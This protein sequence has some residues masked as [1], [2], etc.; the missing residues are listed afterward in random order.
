MRAV[1]T[2]I[3]GD[4]RRRRV[5]TFVVFIIVALAAGVGTLALEILSVSSAPYARA[6]AQDAGAH[7]DVQFDGQKV[8]TAQLSATAQL[9]DVTVTAGP[10][11]LT[12]I[13]FEYGTAKAALNVIGR[14]DPGG[15][16]D[17]L[18]IVAGRWAR[19]PG[20]IV[21]TQSFAEQAHLAPGDHI[22]ALSRQ[23]KP[24]FT[25][26]GEVVD[27]EEADAS[28]MSPQFSWVVPEQVA[29][30]LSPGNTLS[31][32]MLYRFR[33]AATDAEIQR[34]TQE[35]AS[36]LPSGAIGSSLSYL[37]I[38]SIS[39]VTSTLVLTFLL[40]FSAFALGA[41][42]LIVA[43][44]VAGAVFASYRDIGVVKALGFTPGQ[45]VVSFVGQMLIPGL[46]AC[47]VGVALGLL[48]SGPVLDANAKALGVSGA[49]LVTVPPGLVAALGALGVVVVAA[50]LPALR[51][52]RLRP[53]VALMRGVAPGSKRHSYLSGVLQRLRLPRTLSLG[54]GDAFARPVRGVLTALAVLIG[55]ATLTFAFGLHT[56]LSRIANEPAL[57]PDELVTRFGSYP[58]SQ[59]M[60]IL[61]AQPDTASVVAVAFTSV[62]V[63]GLGS[64]VGAIPMRGDSAKLGLQLLQGRW[65]AGPGEAVGGSAFVREAHLAVGDSFTATINGHDVPLRLVG[66]YFDT[67]NLGRVLRFDWSSYLQGD[68]SAQPDQYDILLRP[69][70]D[71]QAYARRVLAN[72]PDF[73]SVV[74]RSPSGSPILGTIDAVLAV[75]AAVLAVI[76]VVGVFNT[77]LLSTRERVRDTATLKTLGM[78]PGQVV[79]MVASSAG[80]LGVVGAALGIPAGLWLHQALLMLM[81]SI[82][83]DPFPPDLSQGVFTLTILLALTLIGVVAAVLGAAL[84]AIWAARQP[85]AEVLRAE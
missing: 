6:F 72:A 42:A 14:S 28:L 52:G 38:E 70:A 15:A 60:Q 79:A 16:L 2:Q 7:L 34:N 74:P 47:V 83:N 62:G 69:G 36:A 81:G 20:E 39:N 59:V 78:T 58:D 77:A 4:L 32:Q 49:D 11:P 25:V 73:L 67:D 23:D 13:P 46:A 3:G 66:V 65:F 1:L 44:V 21:L 64:P 48:G 27:I 19:Q 10:W 17:H 76:A 12:T 85:A 45:V 8:T 40:A 80:V 71:P 22:V 9:P 30:L 50:A 61:Q 33:H 53:V 24:Q 82:V 54:A 55:V 26:V 75:L 57:N 43:N 68:P 63:P 35:I 41:A 51:G 31:Y 5:Q 18:H 56:S 29:S 84:P 37:L